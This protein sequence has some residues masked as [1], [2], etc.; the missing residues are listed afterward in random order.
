MALRLDN[1]KQYDFEVYAP[2]ILGASLFRG[3]KLISTMSYLDAVE[4]ENIDQIYRQVYPTLPVGTP[5]T[6]ELTNYFRFITPSGEKKIIAEQWIVPETLTETKGIGFMVEF[7]NKKLED[8][9]RIRR[10]LVGANETDWEI[11]VL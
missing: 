5:N 11:K 9:E 1:N 3:M 7:T 6:P 10:L 4:R 8:V 2:A